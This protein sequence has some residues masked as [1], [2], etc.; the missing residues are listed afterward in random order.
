N[1]EHCAWFL[2][3]YAVIAAAGQTIDHWQ[4][5]GNQET[6]AT[7]GINIP[8]TAQGCT[9]DNSSVPLIIGTS[10]NNTLIGKSE[11]WTITTRSN[12]SWLDS[13]TSNKSFAPGVVSGSNGWTAVGAITQTGKGA[14]NGATAT[15]QIFISGARSIACTDVATIALPT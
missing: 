4:I 3:S 1:L 9:F 11:N 2:T 10:A 5:R 6:Y 15:V 8:G 7:H 14:L 13:G 12:D